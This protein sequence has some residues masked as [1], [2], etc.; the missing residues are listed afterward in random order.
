MNVR[1]PSDAWP[2]GHL[3]LE[4]L[5]VLGFGWLYHTKC[6][7]GSGTITSQWFKSRPEPPHKKSP[8]IFPKFSLIAW[9]FCNFLTCISILIIYFW[10][11]YIFIDWYAFIYKCVIHRSIISN[12]W[13][14][15]YRYSGSSITVLPVPIDS[16]NGFQ[17]LFYLHLIS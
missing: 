11:I 3:A 9:I 14:C 1:T 7:Y 5:G 15:G 6:Q 17:H 2:T 4:C 12:V 16:E 8:W 10:F 13:Y